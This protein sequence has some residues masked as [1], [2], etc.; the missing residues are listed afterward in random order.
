[1]T[2]TTI[3]RYIT[4]NRANQEGDIE[5]ETLEEAIEEAKGIE[6]AVIEREYSYTDSQLVWTADGGN[7]WPPKDE[8]T[9]DPDE[10]PEGAVQTHTLHKD[11]QKVGHICTWP[12]LAGDTFVWC[13]LGNRYYKGTWHTSIRSAVD[14]ITSFGV[15]AR[16]VEE[17]EAVCARI[18]GA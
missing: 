15:E 3:E 1:M 12:K 5:Y 10:V 11:G 4:M 2:S 8:P 16:R 9:P 18:A 13:P 14:Y 17:A 7:Q 6:G